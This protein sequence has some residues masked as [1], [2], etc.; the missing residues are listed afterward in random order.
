MK[1]QITDK[2]TNLA[3]GK[4]Q[5]YVITLDT[6]QTSDRL[7]VEVT[8]PECPRNQR[9]V[10]W[11]A[12]DVCGWLAEKGIK[13][14]KTLKRETLKDI[15]TCKAEY[16]FSLPKAVKTTSKTNK[17]VTKKRMSTTTNSAT[18]ATTT[19]SNVSTTKDT[20]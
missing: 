10:T 16:T 9:P 17:R 12:R 6:T 20:E 2:K 18:T 19:T 4:V 14:D 11:H 3:T 13:V 7:V 15:Y 1:W 5:E 8:V